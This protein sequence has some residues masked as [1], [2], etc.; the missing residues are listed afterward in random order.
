MDRA[1][2]IHGASKVHDVFGKLDH[3]VDEISLPRGDEQ[4]WQIAERNGYHVDYGWIGKDG[5]RWDLWRR[6]YEA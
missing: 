5:Q 1:V 6:T 4:A 2:L 3:Y